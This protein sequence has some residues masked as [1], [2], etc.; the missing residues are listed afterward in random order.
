MPRPSFK[1]RIRARQS[2]GYKSRDKLIANGISFFLSRI[3]WSVLHE[4]RARPALVR[5]CPLS[6]TF[7]FYKT[8]D[9]EPVFNSKPGARVSRRWKT[10][11]TT[12]V[13]MFFLSCCGFACLAV[14]VV[15]SLSRSVVRHPCLPFIL[16]SMILP[17]NWKKHKESLKVVRLFI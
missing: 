1:E 14:S 15:I 10:L 12:E 17:K 11:Q 8:C 3:T 4:R 13:L 7:H 5:N 16:N 6:E 9:V 2:C